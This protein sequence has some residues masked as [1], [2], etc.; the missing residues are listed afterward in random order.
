MVA[1]SLQTSR[2]EQ[3][4]SVSFLVIASQTYNPR[5]EESLTGQ[6]RQ[7]SMC[8]SF[9]GKIIEINDQFA[10]VDYGPDG[11]RKNV[12]ISLVEVQVGTY[13]LVQGGF[14]IR[15]LSNQEAEET[16]G[17]WKMIREEFQEP[18]REAQSD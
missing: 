12:N 17:I 7:D 4:L 3:T 13:V 14:A 6:Q 10:S 1:D 16:L 2:V 15:A 5:H 9:P 8:L 11:V 18:L